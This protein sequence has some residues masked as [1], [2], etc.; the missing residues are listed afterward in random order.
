MSQAI[1]LPRDVVRSVTEHPYRLIVPV[2]AFGIL[3]VV[4]AVVRPVSWEAAQALVVRDEAGDRLSRPGRFT[5]QDEMKTSQE[6]ILELAKSRSVLAKALAEVGPPADHRSTTKW[7]SDPDLE[8]LQDSVKVTP[9]KGAEFGK[10][11]VFYLKVRDQS[12]ERAVQLAL[13]V[14]RQLQNRFAELRESKAR[15]TTDELTKS[16]S[17]AQAD[18]AE[19]TRALSETEQQVGSD[20][21]EL[22]ILSDSPSGDSDLRRT[23]TE[24]ERELR[25]FR[26]T[27]L[28][29]QE[30]LKLLTIA[31]DDPDKL[32]ASPSILIKVQPALG[33]LKDGLVDAQLRTGQLMGT[34]AE[35]HP[36]VQGARAAEQA[37]CNQVHNEIQVAIRGIEVELRVD[38]DHIQALEAQSAA[39]K[40]RLARLTSVRAPYANLAASAKNRSE[41]LKIVE[42][43]LSEARASQATAHTTSLINVVD[44]PDTGT[45][46]VGPG[47]TMIVLGGIG[48]GLLLGFAILFLT[49][50]PRVEPHLDRRLMMPFPVSPV[51]KRTRSLSLKQALQRVAQPVV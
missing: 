3:S 42:H 21:A 45:R 34:M 40:A 37:I 36:L 16:V 38:A 41:T 28:E 30:F 33:R 20:L 22:R 44:T 14:C 5:H 29:N 26:A 50:S 31:Q 19:A 43:E 51:A 23:A 17:L 25:S 6:T 7:P 11:E 32:L 10:T 4:Y 2:V 12:Q 1:I 49:L 13:A 39:I 18:L 24:L 27:Q 48:G 46:P 47:R 15:S 35:E 8:S 9:P